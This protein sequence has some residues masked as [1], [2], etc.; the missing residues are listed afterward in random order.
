MTNPRE[1]R[2]EAW[3]GD[4]GPLVPVHRK[5]TSK[6]D[7]QSRQVTYERFATVRLR[8]GYYASR[9]G[10]CPAV[11]VHPSP[12]TA[13]RMQ[14]WGLR[15]S[16]ELGAFSVAYSTER[17]ET[18]LSA[19][20]RRRRGTEAWTRLSFVLAVQGDDQFVNA[21][22]LPWSFCPTAQNVY[23]SNRQANRDDS[24]ISL[25]AG[26]SVT[27]KDLVTVISARHKV[28]VEPGVDTVQV[29][30]A[31]GHVVVDVETQGRKWVILDMSA[32]PFGIYQIRWRGN[33]QLREERVLY[34]RSGPIPLGWIDLFFSRPTPSEPGVFPFDVAIGQVTPV[35]Y[36][37]E[38][39]ERRAQW[40][41]LVVPRDEKRREALEIR[42]VDS[43]WT[44]SGPRATRLANGR[45]AYELVSHQALPLRDRSELHFQLWE[46]TLPP[47][48]RVPRL[49]AASPSGM[50]ARDGPDS[51]RA[52]ILVG[53]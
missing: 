45:L 9:G 51:L 28:H 17:L 21:T 6:V 39:R 5:K 32:L 22:D 40:A 38:F 3:P 37:L 2:T 41:Y 36:D 10:A 16:G 27:E 4:G 19:L 8:H 30:D 33:G 24:R 53:L 29:V 34:T 35:T 46:N 26:T 48:Q 20:R 50:R 25:Q 15:F 13:E 49:P 18:L 14:A 47:K 12:A 42:S 11:S 44:F 23:V 31:T 7:L 43:Q 1:R 52:E